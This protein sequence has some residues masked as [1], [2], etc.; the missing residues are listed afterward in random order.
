MRAEEYNETKKLRNFF[1]TYLTL[2]IYFIHF[3]S[4]SVK[5]EFCNNE[6]DRKKLNQFNRKEE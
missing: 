2:Y 1:C 5:E 3:L 6:R 4:D